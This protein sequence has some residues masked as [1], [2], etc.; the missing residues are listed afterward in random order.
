MKTR[1]LLFFVMLTLILGAPAGIIGDIVPAPW[2]R[3]Y[4]IQKRYEKAE[5]NLEKGSADV[6]IQAALFLGARKNPRYIR[7][8]GRELLR[9]LDASSPALGLPRN[10]PAV[11]A[12]IAWALGNIGHVK[13][14]FYLIPALERTNAIVLQKA[15]QVEKARK[16]ARDRY[17]AE[18]TEAG[19]NTGKKGPNSV[20]RE[21]FMK[22]ILRKNRPGP[23]L[24]NKGH[25]LPYSP[26]LYWTLS[27][28][29]KVFSSG[30]K[31]DSTYVVRQEG[32][33]YLN[34]SFSLFS[35]IGKIY[36]NRFN[37]KA[38][39]RDRARVIKV[40]GGILRTG[41]Y[42]FLRGAAALTL[43]NVGGIGALSELDA[44]YRTEKNPEVRVKISQAVL[45]NDRT[46][47]EHYRNILN[48]L[49]GE[50]VAV[51][52]VAATSLREL[53]LGEALGKLRAALKVEDVPAIRRILRKAIENSYLDSI[54]V[55][56]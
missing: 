41:R 17:N 47:T 28:D 1:T 16:Q 21:P 53:A 9:D 54:K 6:K 7:P 14:L 48:G 12:R 8:L 4:N 22:V 45:Q 40:V 5:N 26:D 55:V 46:R 34:I 31:N 25:G 43:G 32:F 33:N 35:A 36:N 38:A 18:K 23:F 3:G 30:G 10:V 42:A 19:R 24:K 13:A 39:E 51:R 27:D 37:K 56:Q 29:F 11:K 2:T 44:A 15:G 52:F 20:N 50:K 49:A